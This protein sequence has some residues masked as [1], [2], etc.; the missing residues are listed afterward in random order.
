MLSGGYSR[1]GG[2][3]DA[4]SGI[5]RG[6]DADGGN[7]Q[8]AGG[9]DFPLFGGFCLGIKASA[10]LLFLRRQDVNA[11][12]PTRAQQVGALSSDIPG[13]LLEAGSGIGFTFGLTA[14][15]TVRF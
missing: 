11:G 4:L 13:T 3:G 10:G 9:I 12:N 7:L 14:L 6:L 2:L 8:L 5:G 1:F 15:G